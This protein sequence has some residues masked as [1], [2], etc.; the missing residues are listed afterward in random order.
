M[1]TDR[2]AIEVYCEGSCQISCDPSIGLDCPE[3]VSGEENVEWLIPTDSPT[4]MPTPIPTNDPTVSP[5]P[6][7][8]EQPTES[9]ICPTVPCECDTDDASTSGNSNQTTTD[10]SVEF[11]VCFVLLCLMTLLAIIFGCLYIRQKRMTANANRLA[12]YNE[13]N[14]TINNTNNNNNN[15]DRNNTD[16]TNSNVGMARIAS[17]EYDNEPA[18]PDSDE[19]YESNG[20][21]RTSQKVDQIRLRN[22]S[23]EAS[24]DA[25]GDHDLYMHD[26]DDDDDEMDD[27]WRNPNPNPRESKP[28]EGK[29]RSATGGTGDGGD[30]DETGTGGDVGSEEVKAHFVNMDGGT[31]GNETSG[32]EDDSKDGVETTT[33]TGEK[34]HMIDDNAKPAYH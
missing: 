1:G 23:N 10:F 11:Y 15:K 29:I 8:T 16:D 12:R 24:N 25:N 32:D 30:G 28:V 34:T 3:V 18:L 2:Q 13:N 31:H 5:I 14:N 20:Q 27:L 17:N 7:P 22:M 9:P 6:F 19:L 33:K 21:H 4:S 26:N